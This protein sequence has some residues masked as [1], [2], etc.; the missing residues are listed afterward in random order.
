[1]LSKSDGSADKGEQEEEEVALQCQGCNEVGHAFEECP[2][3]SDDAVAKSEEEDDDEPDEDDDS[4]MDGDS[5][6][7][8]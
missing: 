6:D 3:R 2:H 5:S 1:M 4:Y 8:A 7:D